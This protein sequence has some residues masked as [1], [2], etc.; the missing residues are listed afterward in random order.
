MPEQVREEMTFH[1]VE[2]ID[3]VLS[4]ALDREGEP[5]TVAA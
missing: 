2:T 5:A 1:P 4:F 3:E